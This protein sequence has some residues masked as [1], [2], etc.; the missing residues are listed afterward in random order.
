[1]RIFYESWVKIS[2]ENH[3]NQGTNLIPA[4]KPVI[5][6]KK[7]MQLNSMYVPNFQLKYEV[8]KLTLIFM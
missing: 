3:G 6:K 4:Q 5:F 2:T 8:G 1:M 7:K